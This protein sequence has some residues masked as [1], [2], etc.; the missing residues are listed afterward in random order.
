MIISRGP[1]AA[2]LSLPHTSVATAPLHFFDGHL[3]VS[4]HAQNRR[5][6]AM[7]DTGAYTDVFGLT[8]TEELSKS[9]N[10]DFW[11]E[12]SYDQRVGIGDSSMRIEA[13]NTPQKVT[14]TF[15]GSTP[16]ATL[17]QDGLIGRSFLDHEVSPAWTLRSA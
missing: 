9:T 17:T 12:G 2:H 15:D 14:F 7:L 4:T 3:F 13:C 16:P 5:I 1:G 10:R 11:E 8:L 6:W